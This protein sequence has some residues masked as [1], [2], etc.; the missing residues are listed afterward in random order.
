MGS[1]KTTVG[2]R[3]AE[4]LGVRFVDLD[5]YIEESEQRTI[6]EL[7]KT[8][9]HIRFRK[10]EHHYLNEVL[11]EKASMVLATGGGAPCYSGNMEVIL[12]ASPN[13]FYLNLAIPELVKR[14]G[15]EKAH[16]PLIAHLTEMEL[17]EFLGKHLFE[18]NGFYQSAHHMI[19]CDG[20]AADEVAG[21]IVA[22]LV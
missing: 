20:K 16:R 7:F 17:P 19:S 5:A 9:G 11:E 15:P 2:K 14:L 21:E 3:L 10:K 13:V 12:K 8:E 22:L 4:I 1:G 6:S 18:R